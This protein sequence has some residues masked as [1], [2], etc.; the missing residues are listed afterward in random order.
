MQMC[1]VRIEENHSCYN[2]PGKP[3]TTKADLS[4]DYNIVGDASRLTLKR[5][6]S[7][8]KT[9]QP[10][11]ESHPVNAASRSNVQKKERRE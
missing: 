6:E 7:R 10:F 4:A 11:C 8:K 2:R 3:H 9:R 5:S 1:R